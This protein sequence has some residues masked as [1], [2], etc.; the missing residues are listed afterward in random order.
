MID[1]IP[2]SVP[3]YPGSPA[4]EIDPVPYPA[5]DVYIPDPTYEPVPDFTPTPI[6]PMPPMPSDPMPSV[7]NDPYQ[8]PATPYSR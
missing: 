8:Q 3:E 4:P 6:D 1:T 2:T 7:P 5:P